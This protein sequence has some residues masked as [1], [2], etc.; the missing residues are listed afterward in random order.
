MSLLM[1]SRTNH[2]LSLPLD[3]ILK[4]KFLTFEIT[5]ELKERKLVLLEK[6]KYQKEV[7]TKVFPIVDAEDRQLQSLIIIEARIKKVRDAVITLPAISGNH[8]LKDVITT[9]RNELAYADSHVR[10]ASWPMKHAKFLYETLDITEFPHYTNLGVLLCI[11]MFK[12][13]PVF[14]QLTYKSQESVLR[15]MSLFC[16]I[17]TDAWYSYEEKKETIRRSIETGWILI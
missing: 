6:L 13:L 15:Q 16:T 17:L 11:E 10:P 8:T 3:L 9:S 1:T 7:V 2:R 14:H 4:E 12:T 5:A